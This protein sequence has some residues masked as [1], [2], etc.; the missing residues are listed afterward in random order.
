MYKLI[1]V[2]F[3]LLDDSIYLHLSLKVLKHVPF[4]VIRFDNFNLLGVRLSIMLACVL[5]C[6]TSLLLGI[7][8]FFP[9][10]DLRI[11][12]V[13]FENHAVLVQ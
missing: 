12:Q 11:L 4:N 6:M 7:P 1:R 3:N 5:C 10:M 2:C 9:A 13:S 8:I